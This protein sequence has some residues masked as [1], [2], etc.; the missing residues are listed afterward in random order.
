MVYILVFE[1]DMTTPTSQGF[2]LKVRSSRRS[3][4]EVLHHYRLHAIFQQ[5]HRYFRFT[6]PI[7][8]KKTS[9][10]KKPNMLKRKHSTDGPSNMAD[11]HQA[12]RAGP[13]TLVIDPEGDLYMQ[14]DSGSL[15]VSRKALS[16]S[17][18]VFLAM[19][20]ANSKFREGTDMTL[21]HNGV[22]IVSFEDDNFEAMTTL[23]RII[24]LQSDNVPATMTFKQL[25]QVAVMCDKYDLKRCLWPW[26]EIWATPYLDC[27][28]RQG[29]EEWL[30]MSI[31][32]Q[33]DDLFNEVTRHL[34]IN[35]EMSEQGTLV[36]TTGF[37]I[38]EG[39]SSTILGE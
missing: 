13:V 26:T 31:V 29:Y 5:L 36:T 22:Q 17:S 14:F 3:L 21:A 33:Y 11:E 7:F 32:F 37:D 8:V 38:G 10:V 12:T 16:L 24:H 39:V 1:S 6:A 9:S 23:A 2:H 35:S 15:L 19:L 25:Y 27:Y 18:P 4:T 28:A 20:G 34:V 30:F